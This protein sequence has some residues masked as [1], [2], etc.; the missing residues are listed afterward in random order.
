MLKVITLFN[1]TPGRVGLADFDGNG[2]A[3][4]LVS[5]GSSTNVSVFANN[6]SPA[7]ISLGEKQDFA[8][9]G[10]NHEGGA[11]ADFDGDGKLDFVITNSLGTNSVSV[12]RNTSVN[13][14]IS[15]APK[16][17]FAVD[18]SPY[19]VAV[20]DIDGDGKTEIAVPV[21]GSM[22]LC[23]Y[24]NSSTPGNITFAPKIDFIGGT[25]PYKAAISDLDNDGK[26]DVA[27][28][29][30]GNASGLSVMKNN[31]TIGNIV[32][33]APVQFASGVSFTV[34]AGDLNNDGKPDLTGATGSGSN[35]V[36]LTNNSIPGTIDFG[37]SPSFNTGGYVRCAAITDLDGDGKPD[38]FTAN[39]GSHNVSVL[40]NISAS[41]GITF[42][43]H[44]DYAT[45]QSPIWVAAGELDGDGRPDIICANSSSTTISILKNII[46]A[47]VV[48]VIDSFTP[49]TA[50]SGTVVT[51]KGSN[52]SNVTSVAF[53]GVAASSFTIDSATGISAVVG[54]GASGFVSATNLYGTGNLAGLNFIG[55]IISSF[56]PTIGVSGTP[57]TI[58]G[59]NFSGATG[60]AFG[61]T[62]AASFNVNSS[63][64]II[65]A[66]L[67]WL[68]HLLAKP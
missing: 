43:G 27:I 23:I 66:M 33:D 68:A 61:G 59:V 45:D 3:D 67:L 46:G 55:P 31:F 41:D 6:S 64:T 16:S 37:S 51:I 65:S 58:T 60:V 42:Q 26:P 1:G 57:I 17:D 40:R 47:N 48:P 56:T 50:I 36:V 35:A 14:A 10:S 21:N 20:G 22:K 11:I 39:N 4:I 49:A 52:F 15:F 32:L 63:T 5:R 13:G 38:I 7:T 29:T 25:S 54:G 53:G 44:V 62:P 28:T 30:Q 9:T 2:M 12:F 19:G 24:R 8:A 18:N 34:S